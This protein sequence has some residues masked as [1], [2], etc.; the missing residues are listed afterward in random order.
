[1]AHS[2]ILSDMN[3]SG[4]SSSEDE[5]VSDI[6]RPPDPVVVQSESVS[7]EDIIDV[8]VPTPKIKGMLQ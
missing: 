5:T 1:M 6:L 8:K 3:F 4:F 2:D 7:H